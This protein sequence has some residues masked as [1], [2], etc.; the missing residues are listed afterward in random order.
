M[1]RDLSLGAPI[2]RPWRIPVLVPALLGLG[3]ALAVAWFVP[4]PLGDLFMALAGGRDVLAGRLGTPDD[5]AFTTGGRVWI[6]QS[7]G[8]HVV[9]YAVHALAGNTGL[10]VLKGLC[11]GLVAWLIGIAA[12]ARGAAAATGWIA[13]GAAFLAAPRGFVLRPS[14][15]TLILV[16]L[17]LWM[18]YRSVENRRWLW[19]A[20]ALVAVWAN[21]HGAFLVGLGVLGLFTAARFLTVLVTRGPGAALGEAWPPAAATMASLAAAAF[22]NP[23]GIRNITLPLEVLRSD[24]WK[25]VT[26]W[27]PVFGQVM[28]SLPWIFF[29]LGGTVILL[30]AVRIAAAVRGK[31]WGRGVGMFEVFLVAAVTALSLSSRR[32]IPIGA[33]LLAPVLAELLTWMWRSRPAAGVLALAGAAVGAAAVLGYSWIVPYY[34]EDNPLRPRE[35]VFERSINLGTHFPVRATE[36]MAANGISGRVFHEWR[37]EGYLRWKD[38]DLKLFMGGRAQQ[39][40]D[41]AV[42]N[43]RYDIVSTRN[44]QLELEP[45]DVHLAMVPLDME[46]AG[47]CQQLLIGPGGPNW[48]Y[49]YCDER[50]AVLADT[51]TVEGKR[52][53]RDAATGR[54]QYPDPAVAALSR[55]MCVASP[56][57]AMPLQT[58]VTTLEAAVNAEPVHF[59][60]S[61]LVARAKSG[62]VD[63][64]QLTDYLNTQY[65]R[66]LGMDA[67]TADGIQV[68][69]SRERVADLLARSYDP[70]QNPDKRREA[71]QEA[72]RWRKEIQALTDGPYGAGDRV[73]VTVRR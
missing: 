2:R 51:S 32:F 72:T 9:L 44:P 54:L 3:A 29:V 49:I 43:K 65:Q 25:S 22:L 59:A 13:A 34:G 18:L 73:E 10:F 52:W 1:E 17:L 31:D 12:R 36:F 14:L 62:G 68:I 27:Q 58:A 39:A 38:P 60:Y 15:F 41:E 7:W 61:L 21:V 53:V 28:F 37:W 19:G 64:A 4:R 50:N 66:L 70:V 6:N 26:E 20:A 23:F 33:V 46:Y 63:P 16:P 56:A 71:D 55:A 24:V 35:T 69:R 40:Y 11:L 5:W 42:W 8:A 30:G 47:F 57:S 45:L 48:A 67:G